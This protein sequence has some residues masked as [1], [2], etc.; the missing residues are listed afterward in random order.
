[1]GQT[2]TNSDPWQGIPPHERDVHALL[3][4]FCHLSSGTCPAFQT[5]RKAWIML[6]FSRV[7]QVMPRPPQLPAHVNCVTRST[8]STRLRRPANVSMRMPGYEQVRWKTCHLICRKVRSGS[9][10]GSG[11]CDFLAHGMRMAMLE[12][13]TGAP[14][15][16]QAYGHGLAVAGYPGKAKSKFRK[17]VLG[18]ANSKLCCFAS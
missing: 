1:M 3:R 14:W 6:D 4:T 13:G 8:S 5:L 11:N 10:R 15:R 17:V 7:Y 9:T 12:S 2:P 16:R 18:E